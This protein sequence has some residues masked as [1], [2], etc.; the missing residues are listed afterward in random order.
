MNHRVN[1]VRHMSGGPF[2]PCHEVE[3]RRPIERYWV[4]VEEVRHDYKEAI[5]SKLIHD[6]LGVDKFMSNDI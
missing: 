1:S 3:I 4:A 5:A 6:Q 2:K